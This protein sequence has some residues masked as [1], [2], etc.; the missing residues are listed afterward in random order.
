M[1]E[2]QEVYRMQGVRINDKHYEVIVRQM[3]K[4]VVINDS[5]DTMFL[6]E[7]LINKFEFMETNDKLYGMKV[8]TDPAT[9]KR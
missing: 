8:V 1:N 9:P 4:K 5:G 2:I 7:P 6:E 3:M